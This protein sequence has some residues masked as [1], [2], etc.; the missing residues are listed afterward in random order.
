MSRKMRHQT[1]GFT[2]NLCCNFRRGGSEKGM[3]IIF[4]TVPAEFQPPFSP[5]QQLH[6]HILS[7]VPSAKIESTRF[8]SIPFQNPTS[9]LPRQTRKT[10]PLSPQNS[11][12]RLKP[13]HPQTDKCA[14]MTSIVP[15]PGAPTANDSEIKAD[16]KKFVNTKQKR[17]IAFINQDFHSSADSVNAY[18]VFA[19]PIP[20]PVSPLMLPPPTKTMDPYEACSAG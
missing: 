12:L 5:P 17:K 1:N 6:R 4:H 10:H 8:R 9:K 7:S 16:D 2:D 19:H 13:N 3:S 18:I 11:T 15:P 14:N 20:V